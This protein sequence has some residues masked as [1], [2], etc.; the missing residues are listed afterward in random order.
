M[1]SETLC[2]WTITLHTALV[3]D[4]KSILRFSWWSGL[5]STALTKSCQTKVSSRRAKG[6]KGLVLSPRL[7]CIP[8]PAHQVDGIA[9]KRSQSRTREEGR[10]QDKAG[11]QDHNTL[12]AWTSPR[13]VLTVSGTSVCGT[14]SGASLMLRARRKRIKSRLGEC[15]SWHEKAFRP[16][17]KLAEYPHMDRPCLPHT[18]ASAHIEALQ[19][20]EPSGPTS[21]WQAPTRLST[22]P[23]Q[24]GHTIW[25]TLTQ[26]R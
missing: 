13:A 8:Q 17:R 15:Q 26:A 19:L 20:L 9:I 16:E 3:V 1:Y 2:V 24:P 18:A 21:S 7:M 5:T 6:V 25:I 11:P 22:S 12:P 10:Q 23:R 14:S 4:Q